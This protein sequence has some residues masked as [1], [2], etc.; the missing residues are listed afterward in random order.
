[1]AWVTG[2]VARRSHNPINDRHCFNMSG[3]EKRTKKRK[4]HTGRVKTCHYVAAIKGN[5]ERQRCW[6]GVVDNG[7]I[8]HVG[9]FAIGVKG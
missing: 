7:D 3:P 4:I 5:Y 8:K 6:R 1:M 9:N 2:D